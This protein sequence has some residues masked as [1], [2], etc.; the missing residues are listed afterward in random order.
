MAD[1]NRQGDIDVRIVNANDQT[2]VDVQP[3]GQIPIYIDGE[4]GYRADVTSDNKLKVDQYTDNP[5]VVLTRDGNDRITLI[6]L[7]TIDSVVMTKTIT[8]DGEGIITEVGKWII[9]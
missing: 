9:I 5:A 2:S 4:S 8:R 6:T 3:S 1:L 7:T